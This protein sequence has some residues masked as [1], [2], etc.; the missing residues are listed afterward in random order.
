MPSY[1]LFDSDFFRVVREPFSKTIRVEVEGALVALR[2]A[3]IQMVK[4][5][6]YK[7]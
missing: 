1:D 2:N 4:Q 5:H 3:C 7:V 6:V